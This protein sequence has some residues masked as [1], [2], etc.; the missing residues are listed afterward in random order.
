MKQ[1]TTVQTQLEAVTPGPENT[2]EY[3]HKFEVPVGVEAADVRW[4]GSSG[5]GGV[6]Q[7]L[8]PAMTPGYYFEVPVAQLW[9]P[10]LEECK[11]VLGNPDVKFVSLTG[12]GEVIGHYRCVQEAMALRPNPCRVAFCD[13]CSCQTEEG[14]LATELLKGIK[15]GNVGLG[16]SGLIG[17]WSIPVP[18]QSLF[19]VFM[20]YFCRGSLHGGVNL[21]EGLKAGDSWDLAVNFALDSVGG[22]TEAREQFI[23]EHYHFLGDP[24][25]RAID[26]V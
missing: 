6:W 12:H 22:W 23:N 15:D 18:Y 8:T 13:M 7:P 14:G 11:E 16:I 2:W 10:T 26:M 24:E 19:R 9:L 3:W 17:A 21:E 4:N 20:Q 25:V 1:L 5:S